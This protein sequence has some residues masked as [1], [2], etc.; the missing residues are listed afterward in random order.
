MEANTRPIADNKPA[1][2]EEKQAALLAK[3]HKMDMIRTVAC[4][5]VAVV[6]LLSAVIV[7]PKANSILINANNTV[8]QLSG[9]VNELQQVDFIAMS[10]SITEL[11]EAGTKGL[12]GATEELIKTLQQLQSIDFEALSESIENLNTVS[13]GMAKLFGRK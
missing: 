2:A 8:D 3:M 13:G 1:T 7:L 6:V 4:V 11:A 10:R 5:L 12:T 9:V